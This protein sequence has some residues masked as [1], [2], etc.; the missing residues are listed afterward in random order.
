MSVRTRITLKCLLSVIVTAWMLIG[1]TAVGV[2]VKWCIGATAEAAQYGRD[3]EWWGL[4][5]LDAFAIPLVVV[6]V[7]GL[8]AAGLA[9]LWCWATRRR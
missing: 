6:I 4:V 8:S 3:A 7:F 1:L 5:A 2:W 9:P